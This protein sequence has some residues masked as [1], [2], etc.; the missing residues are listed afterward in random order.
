[1]NAMPP[2]P[3]DGRSEIAD[4]V[5]FEAKSRIARA[6]A[7]PL[8]LCVSAVESDFTAETPRSQRFF[9]KSKIQNPKFELPI[10]HL[11]TNFNLNLRDPAPLSPNCYLLS[12]VK[13]N[14]R[15]FSLTEVVIAL[16]IF[17]VSMVGVLALFPVASSTG[18]ESSEETQAAILAQTIYDDLKS[19]AEARGFTNAFV[20]TGKNT[21]L[22]TNRINLNAA[23]NLFVAYDVV[24]RSDADDGS[25]GLGMQGKPIA[26]KALSAV[27]SYSNAY[28]GAAPAVYLASI[29]TTPVSGAGNL[30][31]VNLEISTPANVAATNRRVFSFSSLVTGP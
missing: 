3:A 12:P 16:G 11:R 5:F 8:R 23:T 10:S 25:G 13:L 22:N 18:R 4:G 29:Q 28:T 30:A 27:N 14:A 24:Q 20:I 26:L 9:P 19:S 31:R 17:A 2:L 6:A 1:M 7:I 15:A 21:V